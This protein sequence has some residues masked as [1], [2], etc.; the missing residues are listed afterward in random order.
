MSAPSHADSGTQAEARRDQSPNGAAVTLDARIS[1]SI[2]STR[3]YQ[4]LAITLFLLIW[5]I[6]VA[7][8]LVSSAAVASPWQIAQ[9]LIPAVFSE[10]YWAAIGHTSLTWAIGLLI[11]IACAV[12]AGLL[13]GSNALLYDATRLLIDFLR[14]I[15]PVVVIPLALLLYGATS[16]MVVM[17]VVFGSVWPTLLQ[18][19]QGARSVDPVQRDVAA[20]Y[21]VTRRLRALLIVLP[22]AA[23]YLATGFRIAATM[24]LLIA[25]GAELLGGAPGIGSQI[26]NAALIPDIPVMFVYIAT[27]AMMGVGL[28][29]ALSA[30]E[31]KVLPWHTAQR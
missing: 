30:L 18:A 8:G 15:P 31:G 19:T 13:I 20:T 17:I 21:Q 27:A 10:Q 26:Q 28:N 5:Q 1:K 29:L 12:P 9:V 25:V 11:S 3:V 23:P 2:P 24:S 4:I 16:S 14:T 7:S 22:S 6:G